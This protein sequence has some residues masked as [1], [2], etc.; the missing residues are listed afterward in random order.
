MPLLV[1]NIS[2]IFIGRVIQP[3][4]TL[5]LTVRRHSCSNLK[6]AFASAAAWRGIEPIARSAPRYVRER[7]FINRT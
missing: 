5:E 6:H 7:D 2:S 4:S 1:V 3:L